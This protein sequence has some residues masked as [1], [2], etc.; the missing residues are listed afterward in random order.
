MMIMNARLAG[1]MKLVAVLLALTAVEALPT[2]DTTYPYNG[3]DVPIGDWVNPT[4]NGNGKGYPRL[5]EAPAVKPRSA[6]PKNNVNVISLS[7]LP[8]GMNIHYQ[9]PFGLGEAPSVRW[10]TSPANLNK[11][12]HGWSHTYV[13]ILHL[14]V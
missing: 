11:V 1:K 7:Y 8:D 3:P 10:G 2:V 6:H 14:S 9:T 4:I 12:A 5:V 13:S